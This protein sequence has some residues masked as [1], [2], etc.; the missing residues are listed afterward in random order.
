M[1]SLEG[2]TGLALSNLLPS[3]RVLVKGQKLDAVSIGMPIDTGDEVI[4][5][6]VQAGRIH[7]RKITDQDRNPP[8]EPPPQSPSSLE[9]SLESFDFE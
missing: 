4:V 8:E 5:T 2:Q 9:G 3:G 6:S 7:V 1:D